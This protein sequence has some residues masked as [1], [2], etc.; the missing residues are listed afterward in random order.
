MENIYEPQLMI[1]EAITQ[2][3]PD[4]KTFR[5]VFQDERVQENFTYQPGQFGVL[6]VF[7][8]GEAPFGLASSPTRG[9]YVECSLKRVGKA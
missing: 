1:V 2:E 4:I 7:G 3:A 9:G 5:L 6:S 8:F